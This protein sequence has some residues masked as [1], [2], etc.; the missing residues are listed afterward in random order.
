MVR[1]RNT[2]TRG[3]SFDAAAVAA[4]WNK[5]QVVSGN[6]PN[7][8]R[9]DSCGAWMKRLDYGQTTQYGWEIDHIKPVAKGGTDDLSN[10]Q[11]LNWENNR[12]KSDAWPNWACAVKA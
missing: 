5:G 9:K 10:L 2:N 8:F 11:P 7:V 1:N 6:D 4:V 3:G 12:H